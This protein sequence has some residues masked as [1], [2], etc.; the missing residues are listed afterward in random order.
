VSLRDITVSLRPGTPE[1]PGE[2]PFSCT[3]SWRIAR[4]DSV[5]VSALATSPHVGTHADAPLHV[6]DG[7][8]AAHELPLDAFHGPAIVRAV[9]VDGDAIS[10]DDIPALP[11]GPIER[12]LLRTGMSVASGSFPER[13]PALT[14]DTAQA[15]LERGLRLLGVDAPSVDARTSK[16]LLVH[17]ELFRG[18]AN[19]LESLD[20]HAIADGTYELTAYPLKI[21][22]ADAAPVRAVLRDLKS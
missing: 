7:W 21:E 9:R 3:W 5:N 19:V 18:A 20:L 8:P 16:D 1:W 15:L 6:H 12:L 22:G 10:L 4:G 17:Q 2:T 11:D 13:W 14:P